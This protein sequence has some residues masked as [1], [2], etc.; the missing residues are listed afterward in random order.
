[1]LE[2]KETIDCNYVHKNLCL[3]QDGSLDDHDRYFIRKHVSECEKC[4]EYFEELVYT[5]NLL[6]NLPSTIPPDGLLERINLRLRKQQRFSLIDFLSYPVSRIF[7][8]LRI[9][10]QP[11]F[12]NSSAF[13]LYIIIGL[14]MT[15]LILL[16]SGSDSIHPTK[17]IVRPS[18]RIVTFAEIKKF[19]LSEVILD[20]GDK[21]EKLNAN[22][23]PETDKKSLNLNSEN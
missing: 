4:Q 6:S 7:S 22:S 12:V 20:V 13:V 21:T 17:P 18:Q 16:F 19:A 23:E 14:F 2:R 5:G 15:K 3:H 10:L 11:I 9:E 1:M 8:A